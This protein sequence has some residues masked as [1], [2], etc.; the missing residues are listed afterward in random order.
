MAVSLARIQQSFGEP[1][2][3]PVLDRITGRFA[4]TAADFDRSAEFPRANFD[5][6]AEEGLIGLTVAREFGGGGAGLVESLRVLSAVARGEPSTALILFMTY[7]S[8][9]CTPRMQNWPPAI[10]E[11]LARQAV[12]GGGL[13]G[14]LR[15]EPELGTPIR[16]G[17]PKTVARRTADGWALTGTKIYSTGSTGLSWFSVWAKT[18]ETPARVGTFLVAADSPGITIVPAWDHLGMRATVSHDVVF[19]G[20]PIPSDHAID[21]RQPADWVPKPGDHSMAL[22]NALAISTIYDGVAQSARDWLRGYLKERAP[23]NLGAPLATLPRVQEKFGEIEVLL[24]ANRLLLESAAER[25]D[26]GREVTGLEA[27][28]IKYVV[29]GNAIR[30]VEIG[31]E[32][33]GNP[34]LSRNNPLERH[35]RD[36]LCS[37]IHSPQNDTILIAAGRAGLS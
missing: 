16:G 19:D 23:S 27:N 20:T 1:V 9:A 33:T 28:N 5:I 17:L 29:T 7:V 14:G 18:D 26:A 36:V 13:I 37:R 22:W 34:G 4:A 25:V 2:D 30:A 21:V 35:Y 24:T 32:L 11:R 15:V 10:Y 3:Q 12:A 8:Y 31:L 6:L